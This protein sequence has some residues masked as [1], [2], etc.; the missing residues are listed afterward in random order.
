[1]RPIKLSTLG[2]AALCLSSFVCFGAVKPD[3]GFNDNQSATPDFKFSKIPPPSKTDAGSKALFYVVSGQAD[4]QSSDLFKLHD[5]K[6]PASPDDAGE[7]FSFQSG[8]QGGR[9]VV[10]LGSIIDVKQINTYSWHSGA[11]AGQVYL[12]YGSDGK[13]NNF[14][15]QPSGQAAPEASGWKRITKVDTRSL[16]GN[17][18]GQYG[19]SINESRGIIGQYRY[20][21]FDISPTD[22]AGQSNTLFSEID[23]IDANAPSTASSDSAAGPET[24]VLAHVLKPNPVIRQQPR[25]PVVLLSSQRSV[26][27]KG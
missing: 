7:S 5:G 2:A 15:T 9:I 8:T 25:P 23:V 27:T 21:M 16:N 4:D 11:R 6:L 17:S 10:D 3:V 22:D 14:S 13:A 26:R 24:H 1:M 18:P 12:V 19:V 20:L